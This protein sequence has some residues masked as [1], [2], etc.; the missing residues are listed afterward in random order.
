V[1]RPDGAVRWLRDQGDVFG[2]VG[3]ESP[4]MAGA[5]VDVTNLKEAEAA[6]HEREEWLRLIARGHTNRQI[7]ERLDVSVKT[8]ETHKAR[9]MEKLGV[10]SRAGIVD[11]AIREGW[12]SGG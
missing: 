1:V 6:L 9:A 3:G 8:V 2:E 4:H 12:M 10:D 7:A 11:H 5:C